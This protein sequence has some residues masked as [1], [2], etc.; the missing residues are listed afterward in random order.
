MNRTAE[1]KE[2]LRRNEIGVGEEVARLATTLSWGPTGVEAVLATLIPE[3][4]SLFFNKMDVML[5]RRQYEAFQE[6]LEKRGCR[7]IRVRD[8]AV[9]AL[10]RQ[11][12]EMSAKNL[13]EL[14]GK[15]IAKANNL[16]E[17][18]GRGMNDVTD[19]VAE[20]LEEDAT[21]FGEEGAIRLNAVLAEVDTSLLPMANILFGRDQSNMVGGRLLWSNMT[22][23]IR[24]PE[25]DL[26]LVA[27]EPLLADID[28]TVVT[29]KGRLE[30]GDTIVHNGNCLVGVGGRS[31]LSGVEQI[32][33][34]VLGD[35]F[36]MFT[37]FHPQRNERLREHQ[38]TMHLDTF[39]MPG[40]KDTAVVFMEEAYERVMLEVIQTPNGIRLVSKGTFAD[41][42]LESGADI[43]PLSRDQQ[44]NY[45]ANYVVLDEETVLI[46]VCGDG[47]LKREFERRGVTVIDGNLSAVT[48]GYGG[49]H[50][51]LT[52]I[53]RV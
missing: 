15:I 51:S 32:A 34:V 53:L 12:G 18:Y 1:S 3:E 33:P 9:E 19:C 41:Y 50:C 47:Y 13:I 44:L 23:E 27:T 16:V 26:W 22:H 46:T 45:Q 11:G 42:L 20:I 31:N 17:K 8:L 7:V 43:I 38:T 29:G 48:N 37:V 4:H 10:L 39:Y 30:G 52:P 2:A 28:A 24:R 40:P 35:G 25:V 49:A 5:A 21:C 6:T 36:R 14:R